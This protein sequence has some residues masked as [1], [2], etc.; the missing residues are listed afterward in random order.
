MGKT[1]REKTSL[2]PRSCV[3]SRSPAAV[4]VSLTCQPSATGNGSL[5]VVQHFYRGVAGSMR[6]HVSHHGLPAGTSPSRLAST[7]TATRLKRNNVTSDQFL[8]TADGITVYPRWTVARFR[9]RSTYTSNPLKTCW[10]CVVNTRSDV[11]RV[12]GDPDIRQ[13]RPN[14][15]GDPLARRQRPNANKICNF[16]V[17]PVKIESDHYIGDR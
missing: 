8:V 10:I 2:P 3:V 4:G 12:P 5:T 11:L 17:V 15:H 16:F 9:R 7:T 14:H 1:I 13:A 6:R